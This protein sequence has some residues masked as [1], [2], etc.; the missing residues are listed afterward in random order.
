MR[1][2]RHT[3]LSPRPDSRPG[4]ME[5]PVSPANMSL[6]VF[7]LAKR[8]QE[9]APASRSFAQLI[10]KYV[11]YPE[12]PRTSLRHGQTKNR[13]VS[14]RRAND[15]VAELECGH[16]QHVR[17]NPPWSNRPWVVTPQGCL[18]RIGHELACRACE[19]TTPKT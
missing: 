16:N 3:P 1:F 18:E 9:K 2:S 4:L 17:H 6:R 15:W 19:E 12:H 13:G 8:K 7:R 5:G 11:M 10:T 14:S